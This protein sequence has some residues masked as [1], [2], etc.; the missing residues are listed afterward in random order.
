MRRRAIAALAA[1][2]VTLLASAEAAVA[3]FQPPLASR[4][5]SLQGPLAPSPALSPYLNL[6]RGANTPG[7]NYFLGTLPEFDRR[8]FESATL[9]TFPQ[10]GGYPAPVQPQLPVDINAFPTL[11]Q[12][13]HFSAFQTFGTYYQFG[14]QQPRPYYPYNPQQGRQVAPPR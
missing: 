4:A 13:G 11:P 12:T 10:I 2:L 5:A 6:V 8:A 3:Q 1:S 7:I 9:S 14:G